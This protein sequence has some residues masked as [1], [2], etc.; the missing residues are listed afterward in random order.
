MCQL[1]PK[2]PE[3]LNGGRKVYTIHVIEFQ[4]RGLPHAH[5]PFKM[6]NEPATASEIDEV[7][8]AELPKFLLTLFSREDAKTH[9]LWSIPT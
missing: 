6:E 8:F 4:T 3:Y 1:Q 2:L 7:V 5:I 9:T